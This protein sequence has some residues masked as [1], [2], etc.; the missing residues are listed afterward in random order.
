MNVNNISNYSLEKIE[1]DNEAGQVQE[2]Q[3]TENKTFCCKYCPLEFKSKR[4][5]SIH[6]SKC[7]KN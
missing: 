6:Q 2:Q 3:T 5:V 7:K 4:G 1:S